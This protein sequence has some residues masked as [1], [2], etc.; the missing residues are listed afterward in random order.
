MD[1]SLRVSYHT[2]AHFFEA[3][4][5]NYR[6]AFYVYCHPHCSNEHCGDFLFIPDFD[7]KPILVPVTDLE[8]FLDTRIDKTDCACI[9]TIHCFLQFY[10][11]WFVDIV[12]DT[13]H[14]PIPRLL[15]EN[16]YKNVNCLQ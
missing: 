1:T 16:I 11:R 5:G 6:N 8:L 15:E 2:I 13:T 3:T 10:Q 9:L 4:E 12:S 14:C 7:C